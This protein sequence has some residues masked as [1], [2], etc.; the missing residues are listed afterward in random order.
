MN[1]SVKN[2]R[3]QA[4]AAKAWPC[5]AALGGYLHTQAAAPE[6]SPTRGFTLLTASLGG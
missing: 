6:G 5:M 4:L 1:N 2:E 3:E